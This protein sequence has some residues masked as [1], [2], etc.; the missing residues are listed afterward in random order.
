MTR[1]AP[2]TLSALL[3]V[4]LAIP[5]GASD[6]GP[7][8]RGVRPVDAVTPRPLVISSDF[9]SGGHGW[10]AGFADYSPA[11]DR[12]GLME[13][14]A[15]LR[16]LPVEID[17]VATGFYITGH[18]RSDDLFMFLKRRLTAEDGILPGG[19]YAVELDVVLAS[20]AGGDAC[21]G[22]GGHPGFSV[23]LK[24]GGAGVEPQVSLTEDDHYRLNL[25]KGNQSQ[26][27]F[28]ATVLGDIST[29][30]SLCYYEAP[31]HTIRRQGV[32]THVLTAD[33]A[34]TIWL[35][36]GTDS[37]FEGKTRLYYQSITATLRP[38]RP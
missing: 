26:G 3:L 4:C 5:A 24:G 17:P 16:P 9:R 37:G 15:G 20:N 2:I 21:A 32:H 19:M 7:R 34:G 18:N 27:G 33:S 29:H 1:S 6:S 10:T 25:D 23:Y 22:I 38:L 11:N 31:F 36:V 13:L 12:D 14:D 8:K 35:L 28:A 30:S